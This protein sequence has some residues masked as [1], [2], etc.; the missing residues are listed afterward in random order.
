MKKAIISIALITAIAILI[1]VGM[2]MTSKKTLLTNVPATSTQQNQEATTTTTPTNNESSMNQSENQHII[3]VTNK[4]DI[5]IELFGDINPK[6]VE[7]FTTLAGKNFY[8][9]TKFH[10]V[11]DGFMIQ[12]GDPLSKDDAM[13]ARWGTGGPGYQFA[14]EITSA[15]HNNRGTIAMA[16][17]GPNTNGSQFFINV[18]DNNFLDTKHTAFGKVVKGM[19]IVDAISKVA[20]NQQDRPVEAVVITDVKVI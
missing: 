2:R 7:N 19:D 16:N 14:D 6:T 11:I 15:N 13:M 10:R 4:G 9:N 3:L 12:G 1:I 20:T 5:E 18:A 8:D 17:S